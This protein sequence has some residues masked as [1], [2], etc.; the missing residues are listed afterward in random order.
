MTKA[1]ALPKNIALLILVS[2]AS[3]SIAQNSTNK[4][5]I[6]G[7]NSDEDQEE[8]IEPEKKSTP[9]RSA[10]ID[11][12]HFELGVFGGELNTEDFNS[13]PV[14]GISF[15]YHVTSNIMAQI[16]QGS[17]DVDKATFE[18]RDI[19]D[20]D[21]FLAESDRTFTYRSILGG[22]RILSGRSFLGSRLKMSSSI[23]LLAGLGQVE[24]ADNESTSYEL[25]ASYR[26]VVTDWLTV[27]LDLKDHIFNRDFLNDDKTT[28]NV[29]FSLG[30]NALF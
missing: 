11:T 15:S 6:G 14:F 24:F 26:T 22:Y 4:N 17:S 2:V 13:N 8:I 25:A 16:N 1:F 18:E 5:T 7:I 9:V 21:G 30:I 20:G 19:I 27:N 29:E 3:N 23:Y 28:H 12:E 10:Q